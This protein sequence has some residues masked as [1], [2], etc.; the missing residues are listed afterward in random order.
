MNR[1]VDQIFQVD[2]VLSADGRRPA[3][4]GMRIPSGGQTVNTF[5]A[6]PECTVVELRAEVIS[7]TAQI[8]IA[9]ATPV[10][11]ESFSPAIA[12]PSS[13]ATTGF[14]YA[15][16]PRRAGDTLSSSQM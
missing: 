10:R 8:T 16:V 13:T 2:S 12:H 6:Y 5:G 7:A 3:R 15:Y 1:V 14:T 11:M 4:P 9:A